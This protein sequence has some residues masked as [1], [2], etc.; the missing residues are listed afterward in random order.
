MKFLSIIDIHKYYCFV[1]NVKTISIKCIS[2]VDLQIIHWI[3]LAN[4]W[5]MLAIFFVKSLF[6]SLKIWIKKTQFFKTII[7]QY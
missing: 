3:I 5:I 4:Y 6:L 7:I 1:K 2:F